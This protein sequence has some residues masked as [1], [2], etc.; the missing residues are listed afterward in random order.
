MTVAV[1]EELKTRIAALEADVAQLKRELERSEIRAAVRR[2]KDEA[3][4]GLGIPAREL[5]ERLRIKYHL[6]SC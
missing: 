6:P 2:G 1:E 4:R 3:D 5:V